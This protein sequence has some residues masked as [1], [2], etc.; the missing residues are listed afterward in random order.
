MWFDFDGAAVI[1]EQT[2][3]STIARADVARAMLDF[4]TTPDTVSHALG[5]SR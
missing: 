3:G 2:R 5:V 1:F 4:L